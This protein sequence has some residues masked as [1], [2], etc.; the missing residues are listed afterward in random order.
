M[1]K[2]GAQPATAALQAALNIIRESVDRGIPAIVMEGLIY[3]YDDRR[4]LLF[5]ISVKKTF[6]IAYNQFGRGS[7]GCYVY[8]CEEKFEMAFSAAI[9]RWLRTIVE[10]STG[11][12]RSSFGGHIHGLKAFEAWINVFANRAV[13]ELG[14]ASTIL[15]VLDARSHAVECLRIREPSMPLDYESSRTSAL[16]GA[17]DWLDCHPSHCQWTRHAVLCI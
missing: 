10:Y 9:Y 14:N 2:I 16:A 15:V 8:A 4:Q 3:G 7:F 5:G 13:D 17:S 12:L 1:F 11:K 6:E